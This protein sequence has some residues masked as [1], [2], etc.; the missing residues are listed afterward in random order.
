LTPSPRSAGDWLADP[1]LSLVLRIVLGGLFV[2]AGVIKAL[3]VHA[4]ADDIA[5]YQI[6]PAALIPWLAATLPAIEILAGGLLLVGL[7]TRAAALL[8]GAMM[9]VF[10]GALAQAFARGIDL[11]CGC[12]GG[13]APADWLTLVRDAALLAAALVVARFDRGAFALAPARLR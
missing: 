8:V 7:Y 4:L 9:V 13:K 11:A 5:N 10:M 12:F 1:R 6:V 2:Y 3:G